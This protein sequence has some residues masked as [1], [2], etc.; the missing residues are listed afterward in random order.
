MWCVEDAAGWNTLDRM[1][2]GRPS[3]RRS[4]C[5]SKP[6]Q[7]SSRPEHTSPHPAPQPAAPRLKPGYSGHN[8]RGSRIKLASDFDKINLAKYTVAAGYHPCTPAST[9]ERQHFRPRSS[10]V[11]SSK[12][13]CPPKLML[14]HAN[15]KKP[16][17][18]ILSA[19]VF[20]LTP[21][22]VLVGN[23]ALNYI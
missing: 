16:P 3:S 7:P 2:N 21:D 20:Q 13:A 5:S 10:P 14:Q 15:R 11:K 19:R 9:M 18:A 22:E 17:P 6:P 12:P 8:G 1:R 4:R 23:K